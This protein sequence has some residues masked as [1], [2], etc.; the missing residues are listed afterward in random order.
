MIWGIGVMG[1]EGLSGVTG[2]GA[3]PGAMISKGGCYST[4]S[5]GGAAYSRSPRSWAPFLG[6]PPR[7]HLPAEPSPSAEVSFAANT[8]AGMQK[9]HAFVISVPIRRI[10]RTDSIFVVFGPYQS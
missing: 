1:I 8:L 6:P 4:I 2:E 9:N 3:Y 5:K 10:S 7:L